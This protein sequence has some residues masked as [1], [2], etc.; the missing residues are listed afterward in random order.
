MSKQK[1][2]DSP[3]RDRFVDAVLEMLDEGLGVREIN[4]R[5]VARR[6]GYAHTNAYNYFASLEELLWWSLREALER[7]VQGDDASRSGPD[8]DPLGT[9]IDFAIEHPEWYRLVWLVPL[10]GPPPPEVLAYLPVPGRKLVGWIEDRLRGHGDAGSHR[11]DAGAIEAN[12]IEA[13]AIEA[14]ARILHRY[15]HGELA[16]LT[17]G[18]VLEPKPL[19]RQALLDNTDRLFRQLF[20]MPRMREDAQAPGHPGAKALIDRDYGEKK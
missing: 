4:L 3:G 12:A 15:I 11:A 7:M 16:I 18:R 1:K 8:Q 20:G 10:N 6:L 13:N 9:Y 19:F 2:L 5:T 14:G 17:T